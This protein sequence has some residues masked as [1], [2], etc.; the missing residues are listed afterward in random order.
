MNRNCFSSDEIFLSTLARIMAR[1]MRNNSRKS[2]LRYTYSLTTVLSPANLLCRGHVN[3][4]KKW[5]HHFKRWPCTSMITI[6]TAISVIYVRQWIYCRNNR[7]NLF[8]YFVGISDLLQHG[9][10]LLQHI[11][12]EKNAWTTTKFIQ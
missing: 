8:I 11:L 3:E 6:A 5:R 9:F 10:G 12:K 4:L 1:L 7:D 2:V